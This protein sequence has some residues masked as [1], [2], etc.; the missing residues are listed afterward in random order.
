M[1]AP[2]EEALKLQGPLPKGA[3]KI[4]ATAERRSFAASDGLPASTRHHG[5]G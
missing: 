3:L 5:D 1:T 2:P 4:V